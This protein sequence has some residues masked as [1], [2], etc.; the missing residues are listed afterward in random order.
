MSPRLAD[1]PKNKNEAATWSTYLDWAIPLFIF[2]TVFLIFSPSL[3]S[4]FVNWDDDK[5]IL[6]CT[7]YHGLGWANIRWMFST[8]YQGSYM[9]LLWL[10]FA[11]D[12]RLWRLNPFGYH[13]TNILL[14]GANAV[15][16]YFLSL[17]LIKMA[18]P[19]VKRSPL[20]FAAAFS[21]L[22][23]GIHPLRV[24]SVAWVTERRD[25]LSGLFYLMTLIFYL[26]A[27]SAS[28]SRAVSKKWMIYAFASFVLS[29]LS[30]AMGITLPIAL[31][32]LDIY[33]LR[34]LE[35]DI[36]EWLSP[37]K[38][39]VLVEKIPFF[40]LSLIIG[41]AAC[42]SQSP[43]LS[44]I[45]S[46]DLSARLAQASYGV[47]FYLW[48]TVY[49]VGLL[50]LYQIP[51]GISLLRWPF[52]LDLL[53]AA[54]IT[55]GIIFLRRRWKSGPVLWA[56]YILTL[57]P[58]LGV[59]KFGDFLVT[60][61]YSYLPCLGWAVLSGGCLAYLFNAYSATI[62]LG[63]LTVFGCLSWEQTKI[64]HDSKTLW[65]Y[66]L[67]LDPSSARGHFILG[68][69]LAAS[70]KP[71][72]AI[73]Q[74]HE[75]LILD[76]T[77]AYAEDALADILASRGLLNKALVH[78]R[79]I[80]PSNPLYYDS[81]IAACAILIKEGK[82]AECADIS[83]QAVNVN[84]RNAFVI[85]NLGNNVLVRQAN[86][87][88][89][90]IEGKLALYYLNRGDSEKALQ[91]AEASESLQPSWPTAVLVASI[92]ASYFQHADM[93]ELQKLMRAGRHEPAAQQGYVNLG[94]AFGKNND[95]KDAMKCFQFAIKLTPAYS[96]AWS[97][98][99]WA[100]TNIGDWPAVV[101]LATHA[102]SLQPNDTDSWQNLAYAQ[103]NLHHWADSAKAYKR[104]YRIYPRYPATRVYW[105]M[106]EA[107]LGHILKA[108]TILSAEPGLP[109]DP[110]AKKYLALL[111]SFCSGSLKRR[112]GR[113]AC[114]PPGTSAPRF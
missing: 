67:S 31:I 5:L 88:H 23:F 98:W 86:V 52:A 66:E 57:F 68:L 24:E 107:A 40:I 13:L 1:E 105:A 42:I 95:W 76:P 44:S 56:F 113:S 34:R 93:A 28:A 82:L 106:D 75:A 27:Q 74:Y 37:Q 61:R 59:V 10:S 29:L 84:M 53:L 55:I 11:V 96:P 46:Y 109:N 22:F 12:Y 51:P 50:P 65:R 81:S 99:A 9:P 45:Q 3:K 111:S 104:L 101:S 92:K 38:I 85:L 54:G 63:L 114:P 36:W 33:P 35:L 19:E 20:L 30:K 89:A 73:R 16:V 110:Y 79:K 32:L 72:E 6:G 48:K 18:I 2:S 8:F 21:A 17:K 70:R 87:K 64:W 94:V 112:A 25:V 60:S 108:K 103:F 97:E 7:A 69:A 49:P 26:K 91:A 15:L 4:G 78:Y 77:D 14:H 41:S 62:A 47:I 83:E 100:M 90:D 58:V 80:P 102:I 71:E 43:A 39:S